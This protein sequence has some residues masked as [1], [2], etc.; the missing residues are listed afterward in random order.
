MAVR[1]SPRVA[2]DGPPEPLNRYDPR[3]WCDDP[4]DLYEAAY[5]GIH[6]YFAARKTFY[7][8][9]KGLPERLAHRAARDDTRFGPRWVIPDGG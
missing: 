1:K 6:R 9:E 5:A 7:M 4:G 3:V 8:L 2:G